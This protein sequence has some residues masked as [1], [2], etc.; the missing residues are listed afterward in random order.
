ML[1]LEL[2]NLPLHL[3]ESRLLVIPFFKDRIPLKGLAG[4]VDWLLCGDLSRAIIQGGVTG[5]EGEKV[6]LLGHDKLKAEKIVAYGLGEMDGALSY[7]LKRMFMD[8]IGIVQEMG[9]KGFSTPTMRSDF[10]SADYRDLVRP[11]INGIYEGFSLSPSL[12]DG[13]FEAGLI[14]ESTDNF[15]ILEDVAREVKDS[16]RDRVD[17]VLVLSH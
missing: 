11:I 17:S 15:R 14:E 3:A 8:M 13:E 9:L 7:A 12:Y 2:L 4:W 10:P 16:Y 1:R 6:L 5:E